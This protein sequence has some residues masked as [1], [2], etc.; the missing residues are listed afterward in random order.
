MSYQA[1]CHCGAVEVQ[2]EGDIPGEAIACNCSHC[3][4]KGFLLSFVPRDHARI[5]RGEEV[6]QTYTFNK[7]VIQHRFCP[8]CG[9][10]PIAEGNGPDGKPVAMINLRCVAEADLD[11]L[12]I[13]KYD[14]AS[15]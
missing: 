12:K 14:G 2:V 1:T 5:T 13:N 6:L 4:R 10:Q 15:H 9:V 7:H 11:T 8:T 3:R